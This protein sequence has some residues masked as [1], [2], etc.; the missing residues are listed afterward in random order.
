MVGEFDPASNE[1]VEDG[2]I[3]GCSKNPDR[4]KN[5]ALKNMKFL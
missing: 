4:S 3:Q 5:G 2:R 1:K